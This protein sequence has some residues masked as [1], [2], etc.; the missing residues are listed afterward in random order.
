[1]PASTDDKPALCAGTSE[2]AQHKAEQM[3]CLWKLEEKLWFG[4]P[5]MR[6][7][8]NTCCKGCNFPESGCG[9]ELKWG[10]IKTHLAIRRC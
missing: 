10:P 3:G 2:D 8:S 4:I 9:L 6:L 7:D 1:M 5:K